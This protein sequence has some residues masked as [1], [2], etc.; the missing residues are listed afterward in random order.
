MFRRRKASFTVFHKKTKRFT[1]DRPK[2]VLW[3]NPFFWRIRK[4]I[5]TSVNSTTERQKKY[6]LLTLTV[7]ARYFRIF[8]DQRKFHHKQ[9]DY[10]NRLKKYEKKTQ[11]NF[12]YFLS[13]SN[14]K[15]KWCWKSA[16]KVRRKI[17]I[18]W[19][20]RESHRYFY[21][22]SCFIALFSDHLSAR[23]NVCACPQT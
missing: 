2:S 4:F 7:R 1:F 15:K 21:T 6:H 22:L 10:M 17:L 12:C 23:A 11:I 8:L 16:T 18:S 14:T 3:F 5:V 9:S 13:F 20:I 19:D